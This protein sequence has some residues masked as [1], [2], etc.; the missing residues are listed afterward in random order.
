MKTLPRETV[1][2]LK[3]FVFDFK[4]N[5]RLNERIE[6][7]NILLTVDYSSITETLFITTSNFGEI[8][9]RDD[10]LTKA[11]KQYDQDSFHACVFEERNEDGTYFYFSFDTFFEA[12]PEWELV[13]L[14][15]QYLNSK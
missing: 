12:M 7:D 4:V 13:D 3:D 9:L 11:C 10:D 15:N 2:L 1:Q 8:E 6:P 5:E 14:C